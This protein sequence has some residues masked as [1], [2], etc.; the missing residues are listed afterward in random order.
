M[1]RC[2][3][4]GSCSCSITGGSAGNVPV[5]VTGSGSSTD[6][7]IVNANVP[8][9]AIRPC[10]S[11]GTGISY[12]NTTGVISA[13]GAALVT[14]CGITG[15]GMAGSPLAADTNAW[16][17]AC[18]VA[19]NG[20]IV[21]CDPGTGKLYSTPVGIADFKSTTIVRTYAALPVPVSA[22]P[23]T[24][25]TFAFSFTNDDPCRNVRV[26]IWRNVEINFDLPGTGTTGPSRAAFAL[27]TNVAWR[28]SNTGTTTAFSTSTEVSRPIAMG[29]LAPGAT[30]NYTLDVGGLDAN[31][32]STYS[33]IEATARALF[34]PT[35]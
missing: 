17:Y 22:I 33:R 5:T 15:T 19:V 9:T 25:D 10:L 23:V 32:A 2:G 13:T 24:L 34:I 29:V 21:A 12:D 1:A 31:G 7:Y 30:V 18:D 20:G 4:G 8:C 27:D 6:P 26:V 16:P 3:C 28:H 11:G 35:V 14:G